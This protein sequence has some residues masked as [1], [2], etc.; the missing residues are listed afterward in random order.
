MPPVIASSP[1][2][3]SRRFISRRAIFPERMDHV[4]G[5]EKEG[6]LRDL[7]RVNRWFGAKQSIRRA[8]GAVADSS[9][10]F[11][12]LDVGAASGDSARYIRALYPKA[13]VVSLDY[14]FAHLTSNR[15]VK[16]VADAFS[17][18]FP[19]KSFDFVFSSL[20]LHHFEDELVVGLLTRFSE[21]AIHGVIAVDLLRH[22]F[23]YYFLPLTRF[24]F[25]W[26]RISVY[27]G[28]R[29]VQAAFTARELLELA[30]RARLVTPVAVN[31]VPF[32]R[33]ALSARPG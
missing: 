15:G 16:V 8:F 3:P 20:F 33:I 29:S 1:L 9:K 23:A 13:S 30:Q 21:V 26:R 31:V 32:F 11:T 27:D 22:N 18:P 17:L 4:E 7:E 14:R 2:F 25:R 5:A 12:V 10:P 24:L 6:I 19:P 28:I